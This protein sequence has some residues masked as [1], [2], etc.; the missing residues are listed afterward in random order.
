MGVK[1]QFNP[2]T[3][4]ASYNA[5][6]GKVQVQ[7]LVVC[8]D[9]LPAPDTIDLTISGVNSCCQFE[10]FIPPFP[11]SAD[12]SSQLFTVL[13]DTHTLDL[14]NQCSYSLTIDTTGTGAQVRN[15]DN[16]TCD[17]P[18][19]GSLDIDGIRIDFSLNENGIYDIRVRILFSQQPFFIVV[20]GWS[21]LADPDNECWDQT[22]SSSD[23]LNVNC[24]DPDFFD[25][26]STCIMAGGS[27]VIS[28]TP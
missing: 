27:V 18:V 22:L 16:A 2:S 12:I 10:T 24:D 19:A 21:A 26:L 25:S 28:E 14:T 4:K 13:N 20:H 9:C 5:V 1:V 8:S 3:G 6:T 11:F 23:A 17:D 15:Y 7:H